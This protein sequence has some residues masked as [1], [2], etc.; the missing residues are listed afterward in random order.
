MMSS[1]Q[2]TCKGVQ[3][4]GSN[5]KTTTHMSN[6]ASKFS[7]VYGGVWG[8]AGGSGTKYVHKHK[9]FGRHGDDH[10]DRGGGGLWVASPS[11]VIWEFCFF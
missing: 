10:F 11:F 8:K 2:Q 6:P 7:F 1:A 3:H 5:K 9:A 4:N